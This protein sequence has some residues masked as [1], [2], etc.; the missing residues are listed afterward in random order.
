MDE[1]RDADDHH[2]TRTLNETV[3]DAW[4]MES[5]YGL[6][7]WRV[8]IS[9]NT[10]PKLGQRNYWIRGSDF[11]AYEAESTDAGIVYKVGQ[12]I[13]DLDLAEKV[14]VQVALTHWEHDRVMNVLG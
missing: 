7:E 10:G 3:I 12:V 1:L 8:N 9:R 2:Y 4:R 5:P 13:P 6:V 14:T 11:H